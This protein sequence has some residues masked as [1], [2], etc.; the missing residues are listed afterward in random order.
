M[1]FNSE[2]L[3]LREKELAV[4]LLN[5]SFTKR[6]MLARRARRIRSM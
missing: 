2:P 3:P 4:E 6:N 5:Y 1:L